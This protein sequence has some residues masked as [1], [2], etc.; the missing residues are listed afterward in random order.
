MEFTTIAAR[1]PLSAGGRRATLA[2]P[3]GGRIAA[4]SLV[5]SL[6]AACSPLARPPARSFRDER[7]RRHRHHR[8]H[9][10]R[11]RYAPFAASANG[12]IV[13][14]VIIA[15]AIVG[16]HFAMSA[17][18]VPTLEGRIVGLTSCMYLGIWMGG[19]VV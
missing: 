2:H 5:H 17:N 1:P 8:H 6:A 18:G 13:I 10:H 14:V 15:I 16:A 4:R 7:E 11:H 3:G 12:C 19:G 9:R